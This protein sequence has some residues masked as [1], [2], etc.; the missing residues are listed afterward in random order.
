MLVLPMFKCNPKVYYNDV[1]A[2]WQH[3]IH[4]KVSVDVMAQ[5]AKKGTVVTAD[6]IRGTY[7]VASNGNGATRQV[8][9]SF[10]KL[11]PVLV[12]ADLLVP[13]RGKAYHLPLRSTEL[14]RSENVAAV[15]PL[16]AERLRVRK[17][18]VVTGGVRIS[19]KVYQET[20]TVDEPLQRE[21]IKIERIAV[22][23]FVDAPAGI[24][25]EGDTL[26]V[27]LYEEALVIEKR[28][29]LREEIVIQKRRTEFHAPK[30]VTRRRE[31]VVIQDLDGQGKVKK[32]TK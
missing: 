18:E 23:R 19:K 12:A 31:D 32:P 20:E 2:S 24:R 7:E 21:D 4:E 15:I 16:V 8:R 25:E 13:G 11:P 9:L 17:R 22:N 14:D 29:M 6:G 1:A 27:P 10:P 5:F 3:R 30:K 28:L 26:I